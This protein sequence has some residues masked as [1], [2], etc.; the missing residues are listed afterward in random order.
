MKMVEYYFLTLYVE[1][2]INFHINYVRE[3]LYKIN[4]KLVAAHKSIIDNVSQENLQPSGGGDSVSGSDK[5]K[6]KVSGCEVFDNC[7]RMV[8][9]IQNV[10]CELNVHFE[11]GVY[12]YYPNMTSQ[13]NAIEWWNSNIM[14]F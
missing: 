14:M 3:P 5:G 4:E 12:I 11:E 13:F 9:T 1:E 2:D 6:S 7:I 10:K 8:D